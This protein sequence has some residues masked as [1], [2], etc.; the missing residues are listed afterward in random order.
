M[1]VTL[2]RAT[3]PV[4]AA[5]N[6][7]RAYRAE[8]LKLRRPAT[9]VAVLL[10]AALSLLST[11]LVFALADPGRPG[12]RSAPGFVTTIGQLT[13]PGGLTQAFAL[14]MSLIGLLVFV[15]SVVAVTSEYAQGTLRTVL[16]AQPRRAAWLGGKLVALCTVIAA[17]LVLA[18]AVGIV[19]ALAMAQIRGVDTGQWASTAAVTDA[20]GN[21]VN[22]LVGAVLFT[23]AGTALGVLLRSTVLALAVGVAW[24]FPIEHII[25]N[26]WPGATEVF[27]GL[28]FATVA[29]GGVPDA[30]YRDA[31]LAA[32]GYGVVALVLAI[33]SFVR[34]D[35][36]A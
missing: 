18:L 12:A 6:V 14:G 21:L 23:L 3:A 20:L 25:Q 2:T 35:V 16:L 7:L 15:L 8:L 29:V 31:L 4:A 11:V 1:S 30:P 26:A 10:A 17:A 32:V 9:L 5:P 34:R 19:A 24:T 27:P 36:V 28:L 33:T 13:E 22:A